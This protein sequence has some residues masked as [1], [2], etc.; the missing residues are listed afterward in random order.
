M[1]N[2]QIRYWELQESKRANRAKE[3][4]TRRANRANEELTK[5]YQQGTLDLR[6]Q[7]L[8]ETVRRNL[9]GESISL[10]TLGENKRHNIAYEQEAAR[11]NLATENLTSKQ[12]SVEQ[13]KLAETIRSHKA[14]ES[15]SLQNL[16]EVRRHNVAQEGISAQQLDIESQYKKA[17]ADQGLQRL[18]L[19]SQHIENE[20]KRI[21][22]EIKSR[23]ETARHNV[24]QEDIAKEGNKLKS[25]ELIIRGIESAV[26][27]GGA[28]AAIV[29]VV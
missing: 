2:N 28:L 12:L 21:D 19:D 13:Q 25:Y 11:H 10:E 18:V 14:S 20:R 9:A 15:I 8:A 23:S 26:R 7:E 29:P 24:A 5:A 6:A 3:R 16:S 4:E 17:M 22:N 27:T 1:T